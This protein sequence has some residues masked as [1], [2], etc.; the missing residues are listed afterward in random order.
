MGKAWHY[1]GAILVVVVGV[2][3]ATAISNPI[4]GITS[5]GTGG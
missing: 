3:L 1:A 2:W 5:K 4:S